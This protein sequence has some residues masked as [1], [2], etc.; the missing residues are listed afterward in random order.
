MLAHTDGRA[1]RMKLTV[2]FP[3]GYL[4]LL[5]DLAP[6]FTRCKPPVLAMGGH[7]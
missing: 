3:A 7:A 1:R 2:T 5:V 6:G 4:R